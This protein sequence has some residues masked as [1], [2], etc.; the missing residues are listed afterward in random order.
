MTEEETHRK[1]LKLAKM[2]YQRYCRV[3]DT[4]DYRNAHAILSIWFTTVE[5]TLKSTPVGNTQ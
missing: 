2:I 1:N 4:K 3:M 5:Q